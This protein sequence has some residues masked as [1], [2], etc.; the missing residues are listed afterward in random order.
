MSK[1]IYLPLEPIENRCFGYWFDGF[2]RAL[3]REFDEVIRI[4]A[5]K[6]NEVPDDTGHTG[7]LNTIGSTKWK[8]AQLTEITKLF[9]QG[10]INDGDVLVFDDL[11]Y[12]GIEIVKYMADLLGKDI[13]IVG[14]LHGG[15]WVTGDYTHDIKWASAYEAVII[16]IFDFI[17]L[18]TEHHHEL[19]C[20]STIPLKGSI[21]CAITGYPVLWNEIR[22]KIKKEP[23]D[24]DNI[25]VYTQR[26]DEQKCSIEVFDSILKL[27]EH[28]QDFDFVMTSS[29]TKSLRLNGVHELKLSELKQVMGDSFKIKEGL[30]REEYFE[31][32]AKSKVFISLAEGETFGYSLV[33]A[34][35][36]GVTPIVCYGVTHEELLSH[37]QRYLCMSR[38]EVPDRLSWALDNPADLGFLTFR[39]RVDLCFDKM[40]GSIKRYLEG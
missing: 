4:P 7:I 21:D 17:I 31:L 3:K 6:G 22:H 27:W 16:N 34:M 24:R 9:E 20:N 14:C 1:F 36:A 37:D 29:T 19:I 33:E 18:A 10:K 5:T 2:F 39:F 13:K 28:R 32:L 35:T 11:W 23:E 8:L 26:I 30:N 12:P 40:V 15:T 38:E 25:I